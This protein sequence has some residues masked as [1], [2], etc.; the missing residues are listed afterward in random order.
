MNTTLAIGFIDSVQGAA[1]INGL[2]RGSKNEVTYTVRCEIREGVSLMRGV[3]PNNLRPPYGSASTFI[4][5]CQPETL[6]FGGLSGD[7]VVWSIPE[8]PDEERCL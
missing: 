5:A 7:T 6:V 2:W 3:V 4:I 8:W 1:L